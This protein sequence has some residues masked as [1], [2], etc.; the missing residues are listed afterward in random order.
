[1]KIPKPRKRGNSW[2]IQF[3]HEGVPYT[4]TRDT[5]K[6]CIDWV[7][8]KKLELKTGKAQEAD[9]IKPHFS[10]KNLFDQYYMTVGRFKDGSKYITEQYKAFNK[11]FGDLANVSIH[12]ITP[13]QLTIW[14]NKRL[15]EVQA[16]TVLRQ[17]SLYGAVFTYAQKEL[18]L[19][20]QNPWSLVSKPEQPQ[21]RDRRISDAE[22][23]L[24]LERLHYSAD[25][26]PI[27]S[28]HFVAW[29]FLFALET[30]MRVGELLN[31]KRSHIYDGYV[32]LPKTKNGTKRNIPLSKEAIRLIGLIQ[33]DNEQMIPHNSNSFKKAWQRGDKRIPI[34]DLHFHDTRH[35]AIS[36]MVKVRK[37]PVEV[38][39][40]ITGHKKI[41]VLV[42]TY[43]NPNA[44]ELIEAFNQNA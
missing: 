36:R 31:M 14:R 41:E 32:H 42:N 37:L 13:K 34:Y 43:Y 4:C 6:E 25:T 29:T 26:P 10:F 35:E 33:H 11:Y 8:I 18:F 19:I 15:K 40:K 27:D 9:G 24:V 12:D 21:S 30:A 28:P 20:D 38:L 22:I 7:L 3:M 23:E 5:E 1:M 39:A 2:Q 44:E 17:I 16:G